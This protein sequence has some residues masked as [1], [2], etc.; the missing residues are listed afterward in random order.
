MLYVIVGPSGAGKTTF[1]KKMKKTHKAL[2]IIQVDVFS[3]NSRVYEIG[4]GRNKV[5]RDCYEENKKNGNYTSVCGYLDNKY[6]LI[7]PKDCDTE[8]YLIDYPGDYPECSV[9]DDYNWLGILILP[10]SLEELRR[11]LTKCNRIDRL[12]SAEEEYLECIDDIRKNR[13]GKRWSILI[14]EKKSDLLKFAKRI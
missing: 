12:K 4:F 7:I 13:F 10:P 9:F 11:R 14:N 6:G 2:K 3:V 8:D 1:I 5:S